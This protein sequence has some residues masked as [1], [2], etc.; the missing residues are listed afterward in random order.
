MHYEGRFKMKVLVACEYSGR[1]REAFRAKGHD[2]WSC[3]ILPAD[4]HRPF[5]IQRDIREVL[6]LD[7]LHWDI[8]IAF[9]PC[10]HLASSGARWFKEK[11]ADGRQ[12]G[13]IDLF[14]ELAEAKIDKI[15]IENPVGI[16]STRYRK[17]DQIINPYDFGDDASKKTCLWLKNLP[18][19]KPTDYVEPRIIDGKPRWSNQTDSGQN[20]L[21]PSEDRAKLRSLTYMG[22][23]KAM[24]DQ[25]G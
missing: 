22:I 11:E 8:M 16:M 2:A 19:L 24:A 3:D 15:A 9:P 25:W 1:V 21:P 4:D 23:A 6:E 7:W 17:P 12:Q 18:L 5:H 13:G 10:T 20:R 14:M